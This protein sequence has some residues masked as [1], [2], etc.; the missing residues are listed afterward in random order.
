MNRNRTKLL[1]SSINIAW[2]LEFF[3]F[4]DTNQQVLEETLISPLAWK[5]EVEGGKAS[6][7]IPMEYRRDDIREFFFGTTGVAWC[8]EGELER[9]RESRRD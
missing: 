1:F 7:Q 3:F 8:L 4:F 2:F 9:R 5:W 6:G